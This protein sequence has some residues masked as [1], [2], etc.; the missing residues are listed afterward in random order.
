MHR[1]DS[2][3]KPEAWGLE[4]GNWGVFC[5]ESKMVPLGLF[6]IGVFFFL[7]GGAILGIKEYLF[8]LNKIFG[9]YVFY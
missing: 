3:C 1:N 8:V 7:L 9:L 2:M 4:P 6:Q 5:T